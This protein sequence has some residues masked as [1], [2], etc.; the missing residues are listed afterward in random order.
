MRRLRRVLAFYL[1]LIFLMWLAHLLLVPLL[2]GADTLFLPL[3]RSGYIVTVSGTARWEPDIGPVLKGA[4]LSMLNE[5][6]GVNSD[7]IM[8]YTRPQRSFSGDLKRIH[9]TQKPVG[10]YYNIIARTPG[11]IVFDPCVGSA[12][13]AKACKMLG[14]RYLAFE[15]DPDVAETARQRM[16]ETQ[17]PLPG[18]NAEQ[19][20]LLSC[21]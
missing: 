10:L 12:T 8:R 19:G 15:I 2:V 1:L 9:P 21:D 14:R 18:I 5:V 17:P 16:R 6:R 3:I 4:R 11:D 13:T 20:T 7:A